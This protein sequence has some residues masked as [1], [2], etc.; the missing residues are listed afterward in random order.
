MKKITAIA[1]VI[2]LFMQLLP[3]TFAGNIIVNQTKSQVYVDGVAIEFEAYLIEGNNYFKLRDIA[4]AVN[5]SS[6]QFD[7]SWDETNKSINLVSGNAYTVVGGELAKGDGMPKTAIPYGNSIYKDGIKI[8]DLKAYTINGSSFF[9]LKDLA[10]KFEITVTYNVETK[11]VSI[12]TA[13]E[14]SVA[15]S[16]MTAKSP[17]SQAPAKLGDVLANGD[18]YKNYYCEI[19][20]FDAHEPTK[21][22]YNKGDFKT[23][24]YEPD[25]VTYNKASIPESA[26]YIPGSEIMAVVPSAVTYIPTNPFTVLDDFYET[27]NLGQAPYIE[28]IEYD[29]KTCYVYEDSGLEYD[30]KVYVW[31][32]NGIVIKLE[33]T[34]YGYESNFAFKNLKLNGVTE[35]DFEYPKDVIRLGN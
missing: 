26:T 29:G 15:D 22:W 35:A 8:K 9:R 4:K 13:S 32:E 21:L 31:A 19:A 3:V 23:I 28:T 30:I 20:I 27:F 18:D 16:P 24:G 11:A 14:V 33:T 10:E 17:K 1:I 34:A 6:K 5:G 25:L 12:D 2:L 7:V